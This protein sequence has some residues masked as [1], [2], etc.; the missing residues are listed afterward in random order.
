MQQ[1]PKRRSFPST[2][3]T[4]RRLTKKPEKRLRVHVAPN[5]RAMRACAGCS[6]VRHTTTNRASC[7]FATESPTRPATRGGHPCAA[8]RL[9]PWPGVGRTP[10]S[11]PG[12]GLC[13]VDRSHVERG[14]CTG[15]LGNFMQATSANDRRLSMPGFWSALTKSRLQAGPPALRCPMKSIRPTNCWSTAVSQQ[16]SN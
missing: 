2:R 3:T 9:A 15:D 14:G 16:P 5:H 12:T 4:L 8:S 6:C 1:R 13:P 11:G 10:E 7:L